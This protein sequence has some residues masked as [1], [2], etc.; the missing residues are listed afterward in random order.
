MC[1]SLM[2]KIFLIMTLIMTLNNSEN[3]I[4]FMKIMWTQDD[5]EPM[6]V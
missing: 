1:N 2:V 4:S 3:H 6:N 5:E